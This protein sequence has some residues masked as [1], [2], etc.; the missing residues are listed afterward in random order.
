MSPDPDQVANE[1]MARWKTE[2]A[3]PLAEKIRAALF[4]G[5]ID[6]ASPEQIRQAFEHLAVQVFLIESRL[7]ATEQNY[8]ISRSNAHERAA[9]SDAMKRARQS[10]I[11][12]Q[13]APRQ[14]LEMQRHREVRAYV[15]SVAKRGLKPRS[16]AAM[17]GLFRYKKLKEG[18]VDGLKE[19]IETEYVW[20]AEAIDDSLDVLSC[21]RDIE[22]YTE[23]L[24][25]GVPAFAWLVRQRMEKAGVPCK[26]SDKFIDRAIRFIEW[27]NPCS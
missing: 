17:E 26:W 27:D 7:R 11:D 19:M 5:S 14:L 8:I 4:D 20:D 15:E 2:P 16:A 6:N 24:A 21:L 3:H 22:P 23:Q 18:R 9:D 25:T 10:V 12:A 13:Q 1:I